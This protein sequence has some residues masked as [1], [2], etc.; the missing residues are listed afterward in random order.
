MA[1]QALPPPPPP[2]P[3]PPPPAGETPGWQGGQAGATPPQPPSPP[4]AYGYPLAG[5]YAGGY[6]PPP[7]GSY[8][9]YGGDMPGGGSY[10]VPPP[11][12]YGAYQP[13]AGMPGAS[14]A[15]APSA[16]PPPPPRPPSPPANFQLGALLPKELKAKI[17]AHGLQFD[18][19]YFLKLLAGSISLT[20]DEKIRIIDSIPK[21]KQS[22]IDELIRIFEE[23]KR[24]FAELGAEHVP[25]LEKLARQHYEDWV[26]IEIHYSQQEKKASEQ[27]QAEDLRKKL[28]LN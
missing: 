26:D 9:P 12:E 3:P 1:D 23:E 7:P 8:T 28:G 27:Q 2:L 20:K 11:T 17:P 21:L 25:Q 22:Q 4:P 10:G 19:Q 16:G 13:S 6:P 5:G 15:P 18:G 14:G 24:K